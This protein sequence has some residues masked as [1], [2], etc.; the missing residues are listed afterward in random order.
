MDITVVGDG[1][2][3]LTAAIA[4]A[5]RGAN[6]TLLEAHRTLGGRARATEP[7]YVANEGPHVLYGDGAP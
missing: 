3:G 7:P 5:E 4:G 1:L 6:I 2:A